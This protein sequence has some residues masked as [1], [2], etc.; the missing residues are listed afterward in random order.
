MARSADVIA[1]MKWPGPDRN[2]VT[3]PWFVVLV[4]KVLPI[5]LAFFNT[6]PVPTTRS[7][8]TVQSESESVPHPN[9]DVRRLF[10]TLDEFC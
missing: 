4:L 9:P 1:E 5:H 7:R 10:V 8:A 3:S 2:L 6:N